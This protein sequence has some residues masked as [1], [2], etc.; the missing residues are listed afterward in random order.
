MK[1]HKIKNIFYSGAIP[2]SFI[3][4]S[5][6]KHHAKTEI[7]GHSIFLGQI[8]ADEKEG[9]RIAAIEYTSYKEMALKKMDQIREDIFAKYPISCLHVHHSLGLIKTGEICF[10]VFASSPH[11]KAAIDACEE[12]VERIKKELPIWGKEFFEDETYQWKENV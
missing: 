7:G 12:T 8:R 10:F 9:K 4:D 2:A 3:A 5:I 6:Q 11:R 1:E